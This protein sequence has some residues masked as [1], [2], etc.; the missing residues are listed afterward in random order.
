MKLCA[1]II[2]NRNVVCL[3]TKYSSKSFQYFQFL[4]VFHYLSHPYTMCI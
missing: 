4:T 2:C 1:I 3:F